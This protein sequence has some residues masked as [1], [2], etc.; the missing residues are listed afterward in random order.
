MTRSPRSLLY[1]AA[2]LKPHNVYYSQ[3]GMI[4]VL[5]NT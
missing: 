2:K 4:G 1:F 5:I 3:P